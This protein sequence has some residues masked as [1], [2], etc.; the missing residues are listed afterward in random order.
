MGVPHGM[1]RRHKD[2]EG[3]QGTFLFDLLVF[4][5]SPWLLEDEQS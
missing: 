3:D 2:W 1:N 5:W 4:L